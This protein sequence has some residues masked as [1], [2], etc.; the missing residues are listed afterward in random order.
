[1]PMSLT[2]TH[3]PALIGYLAPSV[4]PIFVTT[5][6]TCRCAEQ[7]ATM[8]LPCGVTCAATSWSVHQM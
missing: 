1:M 6:A 5:S 2:C 8:T 3:T 7:L 4:L